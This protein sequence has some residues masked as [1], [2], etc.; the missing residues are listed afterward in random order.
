MKNIFVTRELSGL[1]AMTKPVSSTVQ[2]TANRRSKRRILLFLVSALFLMAATMPEKADESAFIVVLD[3]GHGGKDPGN[4]GT[5]K[6]KKTEKDVSLDVTLKVGQYITENYPDVKVVYTRKGDTYPE[7]Y[8][9]VEIAN[10]SKADMFISIHCN[11]ND[12][13]NA[14]GVETFVMG[15][16]KSEESLKQAMRENASI[17]LEQ[18]HAQ[19]Y[20]GFDPKN[21]DTYI[22]LSMRENAYL[23]KSI[24]LAKNVQEQFRTRVGRKDRGVKQAG[25]YVISFTNMP[26]ILVELGFLTNSEEEVFLHSE[27]GKTYMASA[28]YRAFKEFKEQEDIRRGR[29]AAEEASTTNT[30]VETPKEKPVEVKPPVEDI[31]WKDL[32]SGIKY[33]VQILSSPKPLDK[34][35]SDFKGLDR[36]DEFK[37][38]NVYKYLA[39]STSSYKE[40]KRMQEFLKNKGF[41]DAF[42]IA[43]ENGIRIELSKAIAQTSE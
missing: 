18:D 6:V 30:V 3:A 10:E 33:Q 32:P 24:S 14:Y 35:G 38:N 1:K 40:A 11:A 23:D 26:S 19:H 15:L 25:Y 43:F 2:N 4:L 28:I 8:K 16:H 29:K 31:I 36:V 17:Y 7:L 39:G 22:I 34:K 42:I 13:K 27:D 20:D 9:R 21:P 37:Q 12:N 5:G 41:K